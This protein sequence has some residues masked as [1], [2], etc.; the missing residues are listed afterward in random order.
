VRLESDFSISSNVPC[1]FGCNCIF[2]HD[3]PYGKGRRE[4]ARDTQRSLHSSLLA[5]R[6]SILSRYFR[7]CSKTLGIADE[8]DFERIVEEAMKFYKADMEAKGIPA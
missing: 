7:V 1:A 4:K 6:L 3:R 8:K 5:E 2:L